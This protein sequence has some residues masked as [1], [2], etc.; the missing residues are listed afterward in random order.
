MPTRRPGRRTPPPKGKARQRK[1]PS[2]QPALSTKTVEIVARQ[3]Q[4]CRSAS[5]LYILALFLC[6]IFAMYG[7]MS[8]SGHKGQHSSFLLL[9]A[10]M[11]VPALVV[12][13][14]WTTV[15]VRARGKAVQE[16]GN[17]SDLRLLG[18][19]LEMASYTRGAPD[20]LKCLENQLRAVR[21][22]NQ[23]ALTTSQLRTLYDILW[24]SLMRSL[25]L[26][27]NPFLRAPASL[28]IQAVRAVCSMGDLG[29]VPS[30]RA[31]ARSKRT[32]P[33]VKIEADACLEQLQGGGLPTGEPAG[34]ELEPDAG[35]D[36]KQPES[37]D[38]ASADDD[39]RAG[40]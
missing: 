18:Q 32:P 20:V 39:V 21:P 10:F 17:R 3:T 34:I 9:L 26:S 33:E 27:G 24:P 2:G 8:V 22:G 38:R 31:L 16:V 28:R 23:P 4:I 40:V 11:M 7:F 15:V 35:A 14:L 6:Y 37:E 13:I 19:F 12:T 5:Q 29:A 25:S 36:G 30:L 1:G